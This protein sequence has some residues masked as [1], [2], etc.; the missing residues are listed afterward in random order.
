L[1]GRNGWGR[2]IS[3]QRFLIP[4]IPADRANLG[5]LFGLLLF[6]FSL[7][8]IAVVAMVPEQLLA[9]VGDVRG[10]SRNPIQDGEDREIFL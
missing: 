8:H 2:D 10:E 6:S 7:R 4:W 9:F 5:F 3:G 1:R